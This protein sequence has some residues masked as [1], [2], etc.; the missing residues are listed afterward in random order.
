MVVTKKLKNGY[1]KKNS[2]LRKV[3]KICEFLS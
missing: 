3:E 2:L 1:C